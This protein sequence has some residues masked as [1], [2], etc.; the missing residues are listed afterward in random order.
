MASGYVLVPLRYTPFTREQRGPA[1]W[2]RCI[3]SKNQWL[4]QPGALR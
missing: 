4:R 1:I 3:E 2:P